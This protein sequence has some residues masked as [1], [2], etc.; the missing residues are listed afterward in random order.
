MPIR[1][2]GSTKS[3]QDVPSVSKRQRL[4]TVCDESSNEKDEISDFECDEVNCIE[5]NPNVKLRAEFSVQHKEALAGIKQIV[6]DK[7]EADVQG[8]SSSDTTISDNILSLENVINN[9]SFVKMISGLQKNTAVKSIPVVSRNYEE[10]FMRESISSSEKSCIMGKACEGMFLDSRLPFV[11]TQFVLP[12]TYKQERGMCI[13]CLRKTTQLLFYKTIYHG[14]DIKCVIQKYGNICNQPGEYSAESMLVCHPNGPV[15]C[16]PLP[17][18][19][20]QRNRYVV[21]EVGGK[22]YV[23]QQN[24]DV[25]PF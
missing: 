21:S 11:G 6:S 10:K 7:L 1:R 3:E 2:R 17:I 12:N 24:V 19:A 25:Q 8:G 5:T 23:K 4:Q 16:M 22:K 15:H 20:H 13:F 18:V 14:Y 9:I